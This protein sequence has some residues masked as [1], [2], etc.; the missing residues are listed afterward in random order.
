MWNARAKKFLKEL[1]PIANSEDLK[2][3]EMDLP[4]GPNTIFRIYVDSLNE[5]PVTIERCASLSR[6]LS[7]FLDTDDTFYYAFHLEVSSPGLD[8]P[9]RIWEDLPNFLGKKV[10]VAL[11]ETVNN[12]RKAKGLLKEVFL[13]K[14]ELIIVLDT[15]EDLLI[16]RD[17]IKKMNIIWEG[18]IK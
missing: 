14:E 12:R 3:I 8:R 1:E 15:Q 18:E 13:D 6:L 11:K 7:S 4:T 9:L 5:K 17:N 10:K 16:K 2:I